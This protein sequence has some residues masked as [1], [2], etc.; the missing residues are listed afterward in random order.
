MSLLCV[1]ILCII[2]S[3]SI[4]ITS[5]KNDLGSTISDAI[6]LFYC[7]G[8]I[9]CHFAG[10][11]DLVFNCG[12]NLPISIGGIF[13]LLSSITWRRYLHQQNQIKGKFWIKLKVLHWNSAFIVVLFFW[14]VLVIHYLTT[15]PMDYDGNAYHL[16]L[17]IKFLQ[18]NSFFHIP[19]IWQFSMPAN[20]EA[21]FY[22]FTNFRNHI[23]LNFVQIPLLIAFVINVHQNNQGFFKLGKVASSIV[24]CSLLMM[25]AIFQGIFSHYID[26]FGTIFLYLS[27]CELLK[28]IHKSPTCYSIC[29]FKAALFL[30]IS[31]GTKLIFVIFIPLFFGIAIFVVLK[32]SRIG[33][34]WSIV[35][36]TFIACIAGLLL[37]SSFW[38]V[39]N[40]FLWG[41]PVY[42][43]G[44]SILGWKGIA[45]EC[46][47][48][49]SYEFR[50][51]DSIPW[52]WLVYPFTEKHPQG[53][54]EF[55]FGPV[56]AILILP[57]IFVFLISASKDRFL[58]LNKK[59]C[60]GLAISF[61]SLI[62]WFVFLSRQPR[63]AF[64][65][66]IFAAP[67]LGYIFDICSDLQK[68][69][70]TR[71]CAA[72]FFLTGI[73][74]GYPIVYKKATQF[75]A[76][77]MV[78]WASNYNVPLYGNEVRNTGIINLGNEEENFALYGPDL[79]NRV[80]TFQEVV[81]NLY[82]KN[83]LYD[84]AQRLPAFTKTD[85]LTI[86]RASQ[87]AYISSD[88]QL[89]V[90]EL[91]LIRT[92]REM[93]PERSWTNKYIYKVKGNTPNGR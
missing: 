78:G 42:P 35:F 90:P 81:Y 69:F 49:A 8:I 37:L 68:Q 46:I 14:I 44:V 50:F 7:L 66:I 60:F 26:L 48:S 47:V 55:S 74:A 83:P 41:N 77:N 71:Y 6:I 80:F 38:Y 84:E 52:G 43:L 36:K 1:A 64:I 39:R 16:P 85:L 73:L 63:F 67:T 10:Y 13:L 92:G 15:L 70:L 62:L 91:Q 59:I 2:I 11:C 20:A 22:L 45:R 24:I 5:I 76:K 33:L 32:N 57:A 19:P 17:A 34:N 23:L 31:V 61:I 54:Y 29:F 87:C 65:A 89:S 56:F 25:P 58:Q 18:S 51:V 79:K 93:F 4:I 28:A 9:L 3:A 82:G 12:L 75:R 30:G 88:I 72:V 53:L 21:V 27:F 86:L 40:Y